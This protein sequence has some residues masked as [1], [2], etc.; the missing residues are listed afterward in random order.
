VYGGDVQSFHRLVRNF[1]NTAGAASPIATENAL[2]KSLNRKIPMAA[3]MGKETSAVPG[4]ER[5]S[6][7]R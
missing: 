7:Y 1:S 6:T 3:F 2:T 5:F 4:L